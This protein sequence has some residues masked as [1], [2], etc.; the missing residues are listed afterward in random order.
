MVMLD[1]LF[2]A[3][4]KCRRNKRDTEGALGF[5]V[6]Y[7]DGLVKLCDEINNR[8]YRL[9]TSRVFI[10]PR[11]VYREV[12]APAF[13]D[14]IVDTY[15]VMRIEPLLES[16]FTN[17][18]F[19]CRRGKGALYG[20]KMLRD[21]IEVCSSNYTKDCYVLKLDI[22]GFFMSLPK[23]LLA[24]RIDKFVSEKYDGKDK[25]DLRFL[26][27]TAVL[28]SPELDY[29]R[30]SPIWMWSKVPPQKSLFTN[31]AG[32]GLA[33]G[34]I[35]SQ[36]LAN[37]YL[38]PLDHWLEDEAGFKYHGR[39]VDDFYIVDNSK[40]KLL[41]AIPIIREKLNNDFQLTLHPKK[42]YIQ[43]CKKGVKFTGSVVKPGRIYIANRTLAG[44]RRTIYKFNQINPEVEDAEQARHFISS[45][46]SYYGLMS[47]T[48][49][50]ALRRRYAAMLQPHCWKYFYISGKFKKFVL[51]KK[52]SEKQEIFSNLIV[53]N[54]DERRRK[55][56]EKSRKD[57]K[58]QGRSSHSS[59]VG[60]RKPR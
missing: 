55:T 56:K 53:N 48:A 24:E 16:I 50:Y 26:C 29:E 11:P 7:E 36:I 15:I 25:E 1:E 49:S 43:H 8:T 3:Y 51:K 35:V 6:S 4:F 37:F 22:K 12:F 39:Y 17:R 42:V 10:V 34:R 47:H 23:P 14:R 52:Y 33:I 59:T 20:V 19:N 32:K 9:T 28:H 60:M 27:K 5:E 30:R 31:G 44:L 41:E 40:E 57:K 2:E 18:T 38:D 45:L 13:R 46:N 58:T 54:Y 21:D